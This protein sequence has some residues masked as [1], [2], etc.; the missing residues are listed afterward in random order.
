[1]KASVLAGC[2]QIE[3]GSF[4][5]DEVLALMAQRGTYFD[6]NIGLVLQNYIENKPRFLG[7]G[8]YNEEGFAYMEKAVPI[9]AEMFRRAV[10]IPGL[11]I[12]FGTDAVA[13]AHGR[14]VEEAIVRVRDG[15]QKPLDA[16]AAMTSLAAE[17][18]RMQD[19]IGTIAPGYE[20]DL[21]AVD[22]DP[23]ADILALRRV[24]FVMKGGKVFK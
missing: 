14:N 24:G 17:S 15:G 23:L 22:G 8:N 13:G 5:T 2:T 18:L 7:I 4:A 3:H 6:P 1:M 20:A 19:R 21:V 9:V 10:K 16:I 11:K 12:V